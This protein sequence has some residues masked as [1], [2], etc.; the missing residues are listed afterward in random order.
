MSKD[1]EQ[2]FLHR[3]YVNSQYAHEKMLNIISYQGNAHKT[4][5]RHRFT[6]SRMETI[7]LT[8]TGAAKDMEKWRPSKTLMRL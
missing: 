6:H 8:I 5:V 3:T 1:P 2:T 7:K 4:T